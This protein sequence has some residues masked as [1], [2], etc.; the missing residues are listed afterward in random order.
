[1]KNKISQKDLVG[2]PYEGFQVKRL[3]E[4]QTTKTRRATIEDFKSYTRKGF[5]INI[6]TGLP[7]SGD[8]DG[9]LNTDSKMK[10]FKSR[11]WGT[12]LQFNELGYRIRGGE[13][14]S[15]ISHP[16]R[17]KVLLKNGEEREITPPKFFKVFNL[18]QV[19]KSKEILKKVA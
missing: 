5:H 2:T 13:K 9:N 18:E 15:K 11:I 16:V 17:I 14:S 12:F 3:V 19:E 1:M 7:Y 8:N 10:N 6:K 4:K